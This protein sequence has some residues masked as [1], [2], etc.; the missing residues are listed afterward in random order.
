M[1]YEQLWET[2]MD[3][4]TRALVQVTAEDAEQANRIIE[5]LMGQDPSIRRE[6]IEDN[7]EFSMEDDFA[8]I[9]VKKE[10]VIE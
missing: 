8:H 9:E 6:W 5:I 10:E 7:V 4:R 1:N 2:T 3:P